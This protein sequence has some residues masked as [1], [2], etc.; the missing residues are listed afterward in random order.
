MNTKTCS[1]CGIEKE[2]TTEYFYRHPRGRYGLMSWC[3]GCL[4]ENS[5]IARKPR[6]NNDEADIAEFIRAWKAGEID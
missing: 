1:K 6:P 3:K 4:K 2:A 5:E